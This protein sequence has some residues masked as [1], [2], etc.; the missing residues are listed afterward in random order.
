MEHAGN[1]QPSFHDEGQLHSQGQATVPA[2][3]LPSVLSRLGLGDRPALS[4]SQADELG[5]ALKHEASTVRVAAVRTLEQ[6]GT[7][8]IELLVT[9]LQDSSWEVRAAAVWALGKLGE[10][11]PLEA[12]MGALADED[13]SV[14]AAALRTLSLLGDRVPPEPLVLALHDAEWQVREIAALILGERGEQAPL[15][16]L[17]AALHDEHT[18]VREAARMALG[19]SHPEA[20]ST[21]FTGPGVI[22]QGQ[23]FNEREAYSSPRT[24]RS[25]YLLFLTRFLGSVF[26]AHTYP[27][28][29]DR[30]QEAPG[31]DARS[32]S[33][34]RETSARLGRVAGTQRTRRQAARVKPQRPILR[35]AER[36]LVALMLVGLLVSWWVIAF[37]LH[38]STHGSATPLLDYRGHTYD[39]AVW[40]PD[41]RFVSFLANDNA[42][43]ETVLVWDRATGHLAT[44]VIPTLVV[45]SQRHLA[46]LAPNG[47]Y[48]A[49]L[50]LD[51]NN[52][53]TA[54]VWD[55]ITWRAIISAHYPS[56][57]LVALWS[58]DSTR[59]VFPTLVSDN[60]GDGA[61]QVWDVATGHMLG[62]CHFPKVGVL[63]PGATDTYS[64]MSPDGRHIL[65]VVPGDASIVDLT[66]CKLS[67]VP[68]NA[69]FAAWSPERNRF[70]TISLADSKM[71]QVWDAQTGHNLSTFHLPTPVL[72][73]AWTPDGTRIVADGATEV[74]VVEV[75]TGHIVLQGTPTLV[76][77]QP[78][79]ALSPDGRRIA[80]LSGGNTVQVWDTVAGAKLNAYQSQGGRVQVI[81]WSADSRSIAT[82]GRDGTVDVWNG[83]TITW[84][85]GGNASAVWN[86][87][88]SPDGKF[89]ASGDATGSM[90]VWQVK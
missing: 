7:S 42:G 45:Q 35:I 65:D 34:R 64:H 26:G 24:E 88:W 72:H 43:R 68:A 47:K 40:S 55:T 23:P 80:S 85:Y 25:D 74:N 3:L 10:Q 54:Q 69:G 4:L 16:P 58:A 63:L 9:A 11:A 57:Y 8:S 60:N 46:V 37:R 22:P 32:D 76:D 61:E 13:G 30:D 78:L 27:R 59:I 41:S 12:L 53:E 17:V 31:V 50:D 89:I 77:A 15:E 86:I 67:I 81:V 87:V 36:A 71:V 28:E 56:E 84:T 75:A 83:N 21:I 48:L 39:S 38:P 20:L 29:T 49:I 44:H 33:D 73:I 82:G 18:S 14:R 5:A 79:W 2:S 6:G 70:A 66:T 51:A 90:R 19:Q 52:M 1:E 62:T